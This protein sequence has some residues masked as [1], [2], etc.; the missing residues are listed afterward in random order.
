MLVV[1]ATTAAEREKKMQ[2]KIPQNRSK[3]RGN[4]RPPQD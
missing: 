4:A 3:S 2:R 1:V